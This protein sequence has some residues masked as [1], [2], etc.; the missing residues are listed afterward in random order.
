MSNLREI[1]RRFN[2]DQ[3]DIE[4]FKLVN[5]GLDFAAQIIMP[6]TTICIFEPEASA[7]ILTQTHSNC[8]SPQRDPPSVAPAICHLTLATY[9]HPLRSASFTR[10][11]THP[12]PQ[13]PLPQQTKDEG[14]SATNKNGGKR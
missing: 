2:N 8:F 4:F 13:T 14:T 3:A 12:A 6:I 7:D 10:L 1:E 9:H 5:D 11:P